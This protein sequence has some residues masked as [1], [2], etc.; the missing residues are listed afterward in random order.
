MA[1][2]SGRSDL[3]CS[4]VLT[5]S[6]ATVSLPSAKR[7]VQLS[8]VTVRKECLIVPALSCVGVYE[9]P[10]RRARGGAPVLPLIF[11]TVRRKAAGTGETRPLAPLLTVEHLLRRDSHKY[12]SDHAQKAVRGA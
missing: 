6:R 4:V 1:H 5:T 9:R 2:A 10:E 3:R 11:V 12:P 8:H 7:N